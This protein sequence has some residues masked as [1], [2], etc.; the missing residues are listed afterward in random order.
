MQERRRVAAA[1]PDREQRIRAA[2]DGAV[3]RRQGVRSKAVVANRR[4]VA[5]APRA[6]AHMADHRRDHRPQ[7]DLNE[8]IF[9]V[10]PGQRN[11]I[12]DDDDDDQVVDQADQI[13]DME[14][15]MNPVDQVDP[16]QPPAPPAP[17][18]PSA[19]P[20]IFK[21]KPRD[22]YFH[23]DDGFFWKRGGQKV[24]LISSII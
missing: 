23:H 19:P 12:E 9:A 16:S 8:E 22:S 4:R 18:A 7:G 1:A 17:P 13:M 24:C 3:R 11:R 15:D 21:F 5:G 10:H 6:H 2:L 14:V 20:R